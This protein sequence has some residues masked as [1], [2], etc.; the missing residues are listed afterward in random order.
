[1]FTRRQYVA[2][3]EVL[4]TYFADQDSAIRHFDDYRTFNNYGPMPSIEDALATMFKA[5][6][7]RFDSERFFRA[8]EPVE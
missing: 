5:D 7:S 3:A 8:C 1:M 6:N 4:K 2:I